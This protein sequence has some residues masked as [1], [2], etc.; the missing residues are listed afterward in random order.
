MLLDLRETVRNSKPIKYTL[1]TIICIPFVFFGVGSYLSGG[2]AQYAA[3]VNGEEISVQQLESAYSQQRRQMAQMFGG[4]IP[5]GF[6]DET[7]LRQQALDGL[8][9]Q[10]VLRNAVTENNF[11]VSDKTLAKSIQN[12]PAFQNANGQFDKQRYS[13][14]IQSSGMSVDQ[15]E[16]SFREDAALSQFQSGIIA[17]SFQLPSE[18]DFTESLANQT[19]TVDAVTYAIAP[20]TEEMEVTDEE[21]QAH[22]DENAESYKFPQRVKIQYIRLSNSILADNIDV[23]DE[24]AQEYFEANK[25]QYLVAEERK[26]SHILLQFDEDADD[27]VVAAKT[28]EMEALKARIEGGEA[29]AD[30]AKEF[31]EDPGSATVGGSLGQIA[32]GA[33]VAPFEQAVFNL[34]E[35][36]ELSEPVR[37]QYGLHLIKVD[38]II[39][40]KGESF[41]EAREK[42][43]GAIKRQQAQSE[44]LELQEVLEQEAFDSPESLDAAAEATGL[45]VQ[46]SDWIDGSIDS[47]PEL[48][49][50]LIL[51]T[52]LSED[53]KDNGNNSEPLELGAQD[54]MVL[55]TQEHEGPRQKSLDDMKE[56]ISTT[57]KSEK[58]GAQL[59]ETVAA[60][61]TRLE[62]GE[63]VT[64]IAEDT[65][66]EASEALALERQSVE[67][68]RNFISELFKLPKPAADAP[69]Y[70]S[71]TLT[72]GDRVLLSLK[73][74]GVAEEEPAEGETET[75]EPAADQLS[76]NPRLGNSEFSILLQTLQGKSDIETNEAALSGEA[77]YGGYGG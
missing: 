32:P 38:E 73:E 57:L 50:P 49:N 12:I 69:V 20:V 64:K 61:R 28:A 77:A 29:F 68:D 51:R 17:T 65:T 58:A 6:G 23:S 26:A 9:R 7:A 37:T 66:G 40:E 76:A 42:V 10:Q 44:F 59:D 31:S 11:S 43:I 30:L 35:I 34:T 75:P 16:N 8:L 74:I 25:G 55:R 54:L 13:A 22:Y 72:N 3:K 18:R 19:R 4:Q 21:I 14:Q 52:A 33:M 36:G 46:E 71:A 41:D 62:A 2:G 47:P 24:E 67:F 53:V 56:L 45:D 39:A 60:A 5:E 15:F 1:I 48:S 70:H 27:D 63:A